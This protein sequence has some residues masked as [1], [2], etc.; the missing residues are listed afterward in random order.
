MFKDIAN[1]ITTTI[2]EDADG[3]P[4]NTEVKQEVFVNKKSVKRS[5]YYA[6]MQSGMKPEIVFELRIEDFELTKQI[7]DDKAVYADTVE[8]DGAKY[9]II[10]TYSPS[11]SMI[12]LVCS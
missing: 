9:G 10:R 2:G 8:Y 1:L 7:I 3:Y 6:A 11:D 5:E 4:S 12:E